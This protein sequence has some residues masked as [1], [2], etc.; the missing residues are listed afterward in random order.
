MIVCAGTIALDWTMLPSFKGRI[1]LG[2]SAS[3]F[4]L[5][6]AIFSKPLLLS[7]VGND[8]PKEYWSALAKKCDLSGVQRLEGKTFFF[9][10]RFDGKM[11]RTV[12][13]ADPG[14]F[15]RAF[16]EIPKKALKPDF[17]FVSGRPRENE[18]LSKIKPKKLLADTIE[19][20][21]LAHKTYVRKLVS[22]SDGFFAN[23][24]EAEMLCR[25]KDPFVGGKKML[26]CNP[27][28]V[29][30][31]RGSKGALLFYQDDV[32]QL[33]AFPVTPVDT[34][35]AGDA[36]AGAFVGYLH[37]KKMS[38]SSLEESCKRGIVAASFCVESYGIDSLLKLDWKSFERRLKRYNE[39]LG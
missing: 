32:V 20:Q 5:A 1:S 4:G 26:S 23:E 31:K 10:S 24:R 37:K 12:L 38:L 2:G 25:Q 21:I 13:E 27:E 7:S 35:G 18:R 19:Y 36:F 29:V 39:L 28:F 3:Y 6:C 8:F 16:T 15:T 17:L 33:P 11:H 34:T 22:T 9:K 30:I 14:V